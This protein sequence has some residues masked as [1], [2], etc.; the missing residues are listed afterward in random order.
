[1]NRSTFLRVLASL[2]V[3][4]PAGA[5]ASRCQDGTGDALPRPLAGGSAGAQPRPSS[6]GTANVIEFGARGNGVADDTAAV[7]RA[8]AS[9]KSDGGTVHFPR[10]IYKLAGP[11]AP[12]S[13]TTYTGVG[14]HDGSVLLATHARGIFRYPAL[15]DSRFVGLSFRGAAAGASAFQQSTGAAQYTAVCRWEDCVFAGELSEGIH[16]NLVLCHVRN[17]SF[18]YYYDRVAGQRQR[19]HIHSR[20]N[21]AGLASNMNVLAGNRFYNAFGAAESCYFESG[22]MLVMRENNFEQNAGR[23]LTANG[24]FAVHVTENWF[25]RNAGAEILAFSNEATNA[26]GNYVVTV[27]KNWFQLGGE[28]ARVM[29]VLGGQSVVTFTNNSGTLFTGKRIAQ[30]GY[31]FSEYRGNYLLGTLSEVPTPR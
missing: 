27:E 28:T 24:M 18:G 1:M 6:A 10:G 26:Q 16:A 13:H 3:G 4:A 2:G 21:V 7:Q 23:C 29:T 19:R 9:L 15:E 22:I 11:L 14:G 25:E 17:C 8:I 31:R 20:G 12:R 5:T 30:P